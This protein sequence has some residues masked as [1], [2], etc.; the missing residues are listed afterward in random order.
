MKKKEILKQK[1][2]MEF[3]M[4]SS[5]KTLFSYLSSPNGL[6]DWF[7]D[8]VI[9]KDGYYL[10]VW[11]NESMRAKMVANRE[12]KLV[13]FKWDDGDPNSFLEFEIV[14]DELT[15]DVALCVI[16]FAYE[17]EIADKKMIWGN[18]IQDLTHALGV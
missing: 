16:D 6:A 7:A 4:R 3:S 11:D 8:D 5:P 2:T 9:F 14:Q 13:R 10:F 12:N 15:G 17:S 18:Q 1:I